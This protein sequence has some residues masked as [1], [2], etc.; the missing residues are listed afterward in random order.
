M[1]RIGNTTE[2]FVKKK[3]NKYIPYTALYGIL[4]NNFLYYYIGY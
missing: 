1:N 3:K 4:I 2:T